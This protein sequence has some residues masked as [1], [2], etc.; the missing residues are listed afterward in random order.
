MLP[1]VH[2]DQLGRSVTLS[3]APRRIVSLV[4]S[5]T[6]LL[7]DLNLASEVVGVTRF[8]VHPIPA[9]K[10]KTI[11]G[12]TKKFDFAKIDA[13]QPDLI[14]GNKEE[15]YPEGI[16]Q[17]AEKY[18]VWM[19]D[20]NT[21]NDA[22]EMIAQLGEVTGRIAGANELVSRINLGFGGAP[23][24]QQTR[25]AYLIW[26]E[27]WMAVGSDTFIHSMMEKIGLENVLQSQ[28][29]YPEV[30]L[31]QLRDA[32]PDAILVSSEPFPFKEEH[33]LELRQQLPGV[34]ILDVD[35]EMFSWY[36]SRMVLAATYFKS[37]VF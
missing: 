30:T 28:P 15:N 14:I 35:G 18:P 11:V 16:F 6:E 2:V 20:V 4:P 32:K 7:F 10:D 34:K 23:F 9:R 36:G 27:P 29:R 5:I 24:F 1:S 22:L 21:Y 17:L 13:L 33:K 31:S 26:R 19:S 12:G 8:C 3:R 25:V 37:L